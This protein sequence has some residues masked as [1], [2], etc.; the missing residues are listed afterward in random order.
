MGIF[1]TEDCPICGTPT[2]AMSKSSAKYNGLYVCQDCAKKL[3]ANKISLIRLKKYP[4]EELQK[5]V[6]AE[7]EKKEEHEAEVEAFSATKEIG[8]FIRRL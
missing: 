5:I 1:K 3:S 7:T 2:A 6:N 4:L 8:K